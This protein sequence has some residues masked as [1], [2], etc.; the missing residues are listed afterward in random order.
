LTAPL[1]Q[2][3]VYTIADFTKGCDYGLIPYYKLPELTFTSRI[4]LK[5]IKKKAEGRRE[6]PF[7]CIM[8]EEAK[9]PP[10]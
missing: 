3:K 1:K 4:V 8:S 2:V 9:A 10:Q 5:L 6:M 7:Y